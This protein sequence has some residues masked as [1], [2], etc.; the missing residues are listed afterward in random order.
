MA[1]ARDAGGFGRLLRSGVEQ[2]LKRKNAFSQ[3]I[4]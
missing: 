3:E 2:F 4:A 1:I